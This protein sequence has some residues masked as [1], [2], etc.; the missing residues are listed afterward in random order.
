MTEGGSQFFSQSM[1]YNGDGAGAIRIHFMIPIDG[2]VSKNYYIGDG[3]LFLLT[4]R[5][6]QQ[7]HTN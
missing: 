5:L 2:V 7:G 4:C 6:L 1:S 3:V